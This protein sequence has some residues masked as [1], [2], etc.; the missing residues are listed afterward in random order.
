M[1]GERFAGQRLYIW[2]RLGEI[3]NDE[4]DEHGALFRCVR[5]RFLV[6]GELLG[7]GTEEERAGL[8]AWIGHLEV[9]EDA[10]D[11][12]SSGVLRHADA[13][14]LADRILV[15]EE[16]PGEGLVDNDNL[17]EV[18]VSCAVKLR[19][20]TIGTP[21]ESRKWVLARSQMAKQLSFGPGAGCPCRITHEPHLLP[22][23]GMYRTRLTLAMP[24]N[25]EKRSSISR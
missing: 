6:S 16:V 21:M 17:C 12:K 8:F 5:I 15:G 10:G 14:M 20:R 11:L 22:P 3:E 23:S 19:P 18:A 24:G 25:A 9:G 13:E 1:L 4:A 7:Q 2:R